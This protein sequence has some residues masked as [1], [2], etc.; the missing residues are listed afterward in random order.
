MKNV[1]WDRPLWP[2]EPER[3]EQDDEHNPDDEL[4]AD[5][6]EDAKHARSG[7]HNENEAGRS[8]LV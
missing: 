4:E 8:P 1:D 2:P 7:P 3:P 6:R 5:W